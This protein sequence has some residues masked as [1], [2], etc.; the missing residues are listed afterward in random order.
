MRADDRLDIAAGGEWDDS[1]TVARHDS[2]VDSMASA[3][4]FR[5]PVSWARDQTRRLEGLR[6]LNG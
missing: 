1:I 4:K 5:T 6:K 2:R 3:P